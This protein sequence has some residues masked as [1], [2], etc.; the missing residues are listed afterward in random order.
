MADKNI[1]LV[2]HQ[3]SDRRYPGIN[4]LPPRFLFSLL[5]ILNRWG[6]RYRS[7][8]GDD[9]TPSAILTFDD[10]YE[11]NL[12]V[13]SALCEQG[14][15][16]MLF[17]P[18]DYIGTANSWE[19]SARFFPARHLSAE[20]IK[21]MSE[22]GVI[23][24]SHGASHR[25]FTA[26]PSEQRMVE[27]DRSKKTLEDITGKQVDSISFPFGRFNAAIIAEA[28]ACGYGQGYGLNRLPQLPENRQSF[29][30]RRHAVYENDDYYSLRRRLLDNSRWE[31]VKSDIV[32]R[33]AGGTTLVSDRLK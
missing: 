11:D 10:G 19:Y 7:G 22:M 25:S 24:G 32:W 14:V 28:R 30:T 21:H 6:F 9:G 3:T 15:R 31:A 29:M 4:N 12:P 13:L 23:I 20:K 27:L 17:I 5:D 8:S 2:V 33:L 18:T 16:P 1:I 26:L